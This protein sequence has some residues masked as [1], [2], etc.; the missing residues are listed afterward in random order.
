MLAKTQ[1][2]HSSSIVTPLASSRGSVMVCV[3]THVSFIVILMWM[4][5]LIDDLLFTFYKHI[6]VT[7]PIFVISGPRTG[8][9]SSRYVIPLYIHPRDALFRLNAATG[10]SLYCGRFLRVFLLTTTLVSVP[11]HPMGS[12]SVPAI[13]S[14]FLKRLLF[15]LTR[16]VS[17]I[18]VNVFFRQLASFPRISTIPVRAA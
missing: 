6:P 2:H 15:L 4:V 18:R 12:L 5:R 10:G 16:N 14:T 9:T 17:T 8:N 3:C 1:I 13:R 11:V 7:Q